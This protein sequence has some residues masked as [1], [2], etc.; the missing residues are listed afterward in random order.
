[1]KTMIVLSLLVATQV[2]A[3]VLTT[4]D[5]LGKGNQA[6]MVSENHLADDG[7]GINIAYAMYARGLT[8]KTDLYISVGQT[9]LLGEGQIW[10]SVGGNWQILHV[11]KTSVSLF[12]TAA[13]A[14]T[15]HDEASTILLNPAVIISQTLT[16]KVSVYTGINSLIPVG[17]VKSA[18]FTPASNRFNVPVGTAVVL[19]SFGLYAEADLGKLKAIGIGLSKTF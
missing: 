19:G 6:V 7:T 13:F 14:M 11:N 12:T 16:S 18:F 5:T 4:A 10:A 9:H 1:M 3:Q 17:N 8:S 2:E 15:R